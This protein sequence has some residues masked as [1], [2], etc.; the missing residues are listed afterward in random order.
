MF[1]NPNDKKTK[2]ISLANQLDLIQAYFKPLAKENFTVVFEPTSNY[3]LALQN[4]LSTLKIKYQIL[5]PYKI[6]HFL[7]HLS[8]QNLI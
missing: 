6:N 3:H 5:N 2:F 8:N 4:T 7:K 1:F